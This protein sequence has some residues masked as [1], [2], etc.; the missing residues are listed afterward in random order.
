[1]TPD[2]TDAQYK[3]TIADFRLDKYEVTVGRFRKFVEAVIGGWLPSSGAGKHAHLNGGKGLAIAGGFEPGWD[4]AWTTGLFSSKSNWDSSLACGEQLQTWTSGPASNE[5]RPIVCITWFQA[6]AFCQWDGGFL[7][8]EAEWNYAASGGT[9]Q[10]VYP[11]SAPAGSA[12]IDPTYASYFNGDC[13]GDGRPG[14]SVSDLL[15]VGAKS[16]KGSARWGQ[17]DLAGNA[18]EWTLDWY[19]SSIYPETSCINCANILSV[20][21]HRALRG[22]SA[23]DGPVQALASQR[24]SG[25]P[26]VAYPFVG[27]RCARTP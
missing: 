8:S 27:T 12:A 18:Y 15:F 19:D 2:H 3:A 16:P 24:G 25:S 4:A 17:A 22:G 26:S 1:V 21:R 20:E 10:R 6:R 7:A 5:A 14:C 23:T 11:W 13:V 9:E